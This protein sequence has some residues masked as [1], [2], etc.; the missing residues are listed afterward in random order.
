MGIGVAELGSMWQEY[1]LEVLEEG[2]ESLFPEYQLSL[3]DLLEEVLA[4]DIPGALSLFFQGLA[5]GVTDSFA[6]MKNILV[7]IVVLGI[8]ATLMTHFI[9]IFDRHQI[10]DL[11]FYFIY[12]LMSAVLLKA[13]FQ[14]METAAGAIESIVLFI[15]LLIPTYLVAVGMASGMVTVSAYYQLL[16]LLIFGVEKVLVGIVIPL[17]YCHCMLSVLNGIWM[18]E[19]L[20]LLIGLLEKGVGWILKAA[21]GIVTGLSVFQAIITPVVDSVKAAALQKTLSAIPGVGNA[22]DGVVELV[23]GSAVVVKNSIGIVLMILLLV[24]CAA[25]LL[26]IFGMAVLLKSGAAFMGIMSSKKLTACAD[27]TGDACLMLFRAAG[28]AMLL[29]LIALS[30]V[31]VSTNRGF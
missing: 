2:M 15:K 18:E 23:V 27:R 13:F 14:V 19:K 20:S 26:Q 22:A 31:A 8:V 25:P 29:F 12:L 11:G 4:G 3:S 1:R 7:W 16:L 5:A 28:T 9:E 10:A 6:G 30:V 24:L 21:L 17:V